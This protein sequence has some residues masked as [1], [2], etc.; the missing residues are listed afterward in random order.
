MITLKH[1]IWLRWKPEWLQKKIESTLKIGGKEFELIQQI[2]YVFKY[3]ME[4]FID[5]NWIFDVQI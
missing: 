3:G 2:K 5:G 1:F 4:K